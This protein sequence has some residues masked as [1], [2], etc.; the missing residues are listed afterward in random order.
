MVNNNTIYFSYNLKVHS[1]Y[2]THKHGNTH[3][4]LIAHN[5]SNLICSHS[6]GLFISSHYLFYPSIL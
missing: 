2:P 6:V 4:L 5:S 1:T 3:D